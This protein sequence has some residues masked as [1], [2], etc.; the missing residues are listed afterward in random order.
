MSQFRKVVLLSGSR[1]PI[2][3]FGRSLSRIRVDKLAEHAVR[4][5]LRRSGVQPGQVD[6]IILG[7]AFQSGYTPNTA[8]HT[9]LNAG[10][11]AS[12]IGDTVQIQCGSGMKAVNDAMDQIRLGYGDLYVAGGAESMSTIPY[13]VDGSLRFSGKRSKP[14]GSFATQFAKGFMPKVIDW[15]SRR[16]ANGK[17]AGFWN[18]KMAG[19]MKFGPRPYIG[20]VEDGMLPTE[21]LWDTKS[22]HMPG[23][24]ER[25]AQT[26]GISREA[27]DEYAL[28]SQELAGQAVKSGRFDL[29]VDPIQTDRGFLAHDEHPRDTSPAALAKLRGANPK[30]KNITAGNSSGINDG[31]CALV[32]AAE[33]YARSHNLQSLAVLVDHC[34]VAVDP[35][36]MGLGPVAAIQKLLSRNNLTVGDITLFEI[37][38][39]FAAQY[40]ACEKLLG[41]DRDK[42]NVNGGAIALGHPIAMSGARVVLTLAHSLR[43]IAQTRRAELAAAGVRKLRGVASLC[44]GGG[45][46]IATLIEVD[47]PEQVE[48]A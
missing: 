2:G 29:E 14:Y 35:E 22:T 47:V 36:Q 5:A 13:L 46:G 39:A 28:R 6:G 17:L 33:D 18:G 43:I 40:L 3:S 48:K 15:L 21:L 25:L 44:I 41:L 26:Y 20:V 31:A 24:A 45:A 4:N 37:N 16:F 42:V 10:F 12:A 8:R 1:T 30:V 27:M 7:H 32:V 23:T 34:R 38:E 9:W 11:P 19:L